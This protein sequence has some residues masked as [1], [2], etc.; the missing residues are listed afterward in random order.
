MVMM[1]KER[2]SP[3]RLSDCT[4]PGFDSWSVREEN[5]DGRIRVEDDR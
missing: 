4:I 3:L 2:R 5:D 1:Q